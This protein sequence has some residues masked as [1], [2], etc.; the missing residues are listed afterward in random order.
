MNSSLRSLPISTIRLLA[1]L[2]IAVL[3][4]CC[5]ED[6][7]QLSSALDKIPID[8]KTVAPQKSEVHQ[9]A[10]NA[11]VLKGFFA[12][13]NCG[14]SEGDSI[15]TYTLQSLNHNSYRLSSGVGDGSALF[16]RTAGSDDYQDGN[17]VYAITSCKYLYG[18]S[19][20]FDDKV[21]ISVT[22]P[23]TYHIDDVGASEGCSR[24]PAPYWGIASFGSDGSLEATFSGLTS[25]L[26]IDSSI[27]PIGTKAVVLTTHYFTD[28]IG[29]G[30]PVDGDGEPLSGTFD[31]VLE[32]GAKLAANPIFYSFDTLRV[33]L[34]DNAK[35]Y[36]DLYIPVVAGSYTALNVIA[37][38][39]DSKYPYEWEGQLLKAF[40]KDASFRV[41]TIVTCE[42]ESTGIRT[43]KI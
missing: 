29:E 30:K 23:R 43:P 7:G 15:W 14:W 34:G 8:S 38:T 9:A 13:D 28:L 37:V 16:T 19:A 27:L 17:T 41:N 2:P 1:C 35:A 39:R 21:Q 12:A 36:K 6:D 18:L 26:K 20:T 40:R 25:L 10:P 3:L 31:T 32:E 11:A 4:A 42:Q 33:N 5:S 24:M 22:I